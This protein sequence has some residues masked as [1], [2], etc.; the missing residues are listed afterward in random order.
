[1]DLICRNSGQRYFDEFNKLSEENGLNNLLP[2][3]LT[4]RGDTMILNATFLVSKDHIIGFKDI[5]CR[6]R[7]EDGIIGFIIE[8]TGPWPPFSFISIKEIS[9]AK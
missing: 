1:M 8:V 3:E 6:L 7:K 9:N 5:A 2:K 4:G